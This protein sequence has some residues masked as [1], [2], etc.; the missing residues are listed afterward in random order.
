MVPLVAHLHGQAR[1]LL[2]AQRLA[3]RHSGHADLCEVD[4]FHAI[5]GLGVQTAGSGAHH[6]VDV[7]CEIFTCS[8]GRDGE[9][10]VR[11]GVQDTKAQVHI[12]MGALYPHKDQ[13]AHPA[14]T[15]GSGRPV[16]EDGRV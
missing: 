16:S 6:G 2:V 4:V 10:Q 13:P 5:I 11:L 14:L 3:L 15:R 8:A 12:G 7:G 9:V 1:G